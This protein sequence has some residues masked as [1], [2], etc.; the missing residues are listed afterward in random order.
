[1]TRNPAKAKLDP[2]VDVVRGDF[3]DPASL[4][5]AVRGVDRIFSLTL[6]PQTGVHE[7]NLARAAKTAGV[8]HIMKL[9]A[10]GGDGETKNDIRKWHD[11]GEHAIREAG[12]PL[13][14]LHP[15]AFMSN[16]LHWR[17]TIRAAGKVFSK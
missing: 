11:E 3:E 12:I 16:A 17:E 4:D 6:G 7:T 15:G 10:M 8:R 9:S 1:M 5:E 2:R 14:V 13:T